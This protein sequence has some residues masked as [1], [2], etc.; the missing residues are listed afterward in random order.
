MLIENIDKEYFSTLFITRAESIPVESI[1]LPKRALNIVKAQKAKNSH[2]AISIIF[3]DLPTMDGIGEKTILDSK[4]S[5]RQFIQ[6]VE[7]ATEPQLKKL[8]AGCDELLSS[9]K[10]NLVEAF[11]AVLE[12]YL[13]EKHKKNYERDLD[14]INKRFGLNGNKQYTFEDIGT[15]YNVSKQ[16]IEQ[17]ESKIIKQL[18]LLLKGELKTK[19]WKLCSLLIEN[20][21]EALECFEG[22]NPILLKVDAER[23]LQDKYNETLPIEYF[24]LFMKVLGYTKTPRKVL[25]FRGEITES[26]IQTAN[27]KKKDLESIFQA[28][29]IIYDNVDSIPIFELTVLV[30]KKLKKPSKTIN[31]SISIAISSIED[32][33]YDGE[34]VTVKFSRLRSAADKA[35]R[36]LESHEKSMHF[37]KINKEINLLCK[38]NSDFT[39]ILETNLKNQIVADTR[40]TPIGR[41][42][43]W[44]LS[45]WEN[46]SNLTIIQAIEKV[47]HLSGKP[48]KFNQ[49]VEEIENI[50]PDASVKSLKVYLNDQKLFTRVGVNEF[51]LNAW[52]LPAAQKRQVNRSISELEFTNAIKDVLLTSNPIVLSSLI[53]S[54][55]TTTKLSQASIRQRL[56][57]TSGLEINAQSG[58]RSKLVTCSNLDLIKPR[59]KRVLLRDRVQ[60][61]IK[62]ILFEQPNIPMLKGNLYLEVLKVIECQRPTFYQYL[63]KMKG[64]T[65]YQENNKYYAMYSHHE[66]VEKIAVD[67]GK[68]T[69]NNLILSALERPLE[70]LTLEKVDLALYE[71]GLLFETSL[72]AYLKQQKTLGKMTVNSKDLSKLFLMINCVVREGVVTKGHH[73]NT[74]REER[75]DRAHGEVPSKE[76][77]HILFNKAHYIADLFVKY[78]CMFKQMTA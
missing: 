66:T 13:T 71:L 14:I 76:E 62:A 34:F 54:I 28:L 21:N 45:K 20:F 44:A 19:G 32:I 9:A 61:E 68:Y 78:I 58:K 42:G 4:S 48:L 53:K 25:G 39:P 57:V 73:L 27:Y 40:F 75:N 52:R 3:K 50:R 17:I 16:R 43:E 56:L 5:I 29:D 74:L 72:K 11:P 6:T 77:R 8:I 35:Y 10:G 49:I 64:I 38:S 41:S 69:S 30:K 37:S 59:I 15:F 18:A 23:I 26:W 1:G 22:F 67:V 63:D 55:E 60:D 51:A 12:L 2:E 46:T 36:V 65:Q 7:K 31:Q 47:L 24:N 33:D 70:M